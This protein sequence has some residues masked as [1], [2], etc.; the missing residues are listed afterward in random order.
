M[1]SRSLFLQAIWWLRRRLKPDTQTTWDKAPRRRKDPRTPA[2]A[3]L[4][5]GIIRPPTPRRRSWER[6]SLSPGR[7]R[8]YLLNYAR[9]NEALSLH[10]TVPD[11]EAMK[12]KFEEI[13]GFP[14]N[15]ELI[16]CAPWRQ[17]LLLADRYRDGRVFLA[18]DSVH[19]VIPTGGL[20]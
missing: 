4:L 7:Y 19:L 10:A 14:V 11:S 16:S 13:V 17:N 9:F 3:L 12:H 6:P 2:S 1:A 18:G 20:G 8:A 5:R 15:Y